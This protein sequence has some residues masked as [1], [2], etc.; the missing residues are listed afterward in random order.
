MANKLKAVFSNKK[1]EMGGTIHFRDKK[2]KEEFERKLEII[3]E[4]GHPEEVD[5]VLSVS[6]IIQ[7]GDMKYPFMIAENIDRF[8]VSPSVEKKEITVD[9]K[10]G[11]RIVALEKLNVK[12]AVILKTKAQSVAFLQFNFMPDSGQV[13]V[14]YRMQLEYATSTQAVAE[15]YAIALGIINKLFIIGDNLEGNE[16]ITTLQNTLS[17]IS[18]LFEHIT[19]IGQ[20]LHLDFDP[21]KST[22]TADEIKDIEELYVLLVLQKTIR[23]NAKLTSTEAT[24]IT[25]NPD[26]EIPEKGGEIGL[27]FT[28]THKY[29][30][31]G[32]EITIYSSNFLFNAIVKDIITTPEGNVKVLYG[33]TDNQPMYIS[34]KGFSSEDEAM[35]EQKLII[36][37]SEEY[38]HAKTVQDYLIEQ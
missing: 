18:S 7:D 22:R 2:A 16:T 9:T 34:L 17:H 19:L 27:T 38:K 26:V 3:Y 36:E 12:D 24:G 13:Q 35:A 15:E 8:M 20:L 28:G 30:I 10:Y 6:T 14:T 23:I 11:K 1:Y 25:F 21:Q 32:E 33:D 31:C 29:C 5:G 4:E 37:H